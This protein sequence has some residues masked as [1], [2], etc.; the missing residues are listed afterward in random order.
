MAA[1]GARVARHQVRGGPLGRTL[2]PLP[3]PSATPSL[4]PLLLASPQPGSPGCPVLRGV[5]CSGGPTRGVARKNRA[6]PPGLDCGL[7]QVVHARAAWARRAGPPQTAW[8]AVASQAARPRSRRPC[9][10]RAHARSETTS[11][12]HGGRLLPGGPPPRAWRPP[13]PPG[14]WWPVAEPTR[15]PLAPTLRGRARHTRTPGRAG[16]W[17]AGP[18]LTARDVLA[19]RWLAEQYAA[20]TDTL[21]VLLGRLS[22]ATPEAPGQVAARTVRHHL[23]RWVRAGLVVRTR[24]LGRAW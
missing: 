7:E 11:P 12:A 8:R 4:T 17:D 24:R 23:D 2:T 6:R 19:V 13:S 10:P 22:P 3:I 21:A 14:W 9:G 5:A 18:V 15:T 20:T 1:G 16:R